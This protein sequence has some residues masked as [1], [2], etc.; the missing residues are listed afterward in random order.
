LVD[1]TPGEVAAI[2]DDE[3]IA[4]DDDGAL[5]IPRS[6]AERQA[7]GDRELQRF[8]GVA[9]RGVSG[10]VV[11]ELTGVSGATGA[12]NAG[13]TEALAQALV[14]IASRVG[15][16]D[17]FYRLSNDTG[18]RELRI[19]IELVA[20]MTDARACAQMVGAGISFAAMPLGL[21]APLVSIP[22]SEVVLRTTRWIND[23]FHGIDRAQVAR[24]LNDFAL[25]EVSQNENIPEGQQHPEYA[26]DTLVQLGLSRS[27]WEDDRTR[28]RADQYILMRMT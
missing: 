15:E 3:P 18:G 11:S 20:Y 8:S 4:G 23:R 21:F 9:A 17:P 1:R 27:L 22:A 2:T 25:H 28:F 24:T 19:C 13:H 10:R 26:V 12:V 6:A 5:L 14:R 7:L 16:N